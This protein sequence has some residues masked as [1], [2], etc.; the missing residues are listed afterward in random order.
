MLNKSNPLQN[1]SAEV[2]MNRC[3]QEGDM[4]ACYQLRYSQKAHKMGGPQMAATTVGKQGVV[5]M[6]DGGMMDEE[7]LLAPDPGMMGDEGLTT[8]ED[9][10]LPIMDVI[11]EEAYMQL[12]QAMGEYPIVA[13]IAEMAIKSGEGYV[14]GEGGP[15]DD[16]VPARLSSGEYVFSAEAVAALG[17]DKL[18]ELHEY[19]KSIAASS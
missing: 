19:G 3:Q 14:E 17:V 12:L 7:S 16:L 2:L 8:P 15:T 4:D 13:R 10:F 11:G 1:P 5:G 9:P 6:A 18:E